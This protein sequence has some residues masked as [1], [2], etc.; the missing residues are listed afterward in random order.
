MGTDITRGCSFFTLACCDIL[1]GPRALKIINDDRWYVKA[2]FGCKGTR[3][4]ANVRSSTVVT[5]L[6]AGHLCL[7][8]IKFSTANSPPHAINFYFQTPCLRARLRSVNCHETNIF[9]LFAQDMK[10]CFWLAA[11]PFRTRTTTS[12]NGR[13]WCIGPVVFIFHSSLFAR[14]RTY[15]TASWDVLVYL[16]STFAIVVYTLCYCRSNFFGLSGKPFK[17]KDCFSRPSPTPTLN[18]K[19]NQRGIC[20]KC[21]YL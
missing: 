14:T 15:A 13:T 18:T 12:L 5:Q 2:C 11:L 19:L 1:L 3:G 4:D 8:V 6:V 16:T 7:V 17:W 21:S 10:S 9:S 20:R